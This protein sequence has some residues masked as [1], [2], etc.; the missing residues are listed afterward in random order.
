MVNADAIS[1]I[2]SGLIITIVFMMVLTTL[3]A[4]KIHELESRIEKLENK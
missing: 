1:S 4:I 2:I 3:L